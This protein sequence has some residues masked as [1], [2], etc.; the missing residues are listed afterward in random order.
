MHPHHSLLVSHARE[1]RRT[2]I[3]LYLPH[4]RERSDAPTPFSSC[5]TC[6]R[7]QTHP[8]HS[9]LVSHA[10]EV[11]RTHTILYLPHMRERSDAPTPFSTC[12]TCERGQTHPHH[13]LL[14]CLM[15]ERGQT[16]LT[17]LH[18]PHVRSTR[19]GKHHIADYHTFPPLLHVARV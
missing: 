16:H 10:R 8:H 19:D 12:L 15:C 18:L 4:M 5:L 3:I 13:S 11:R 7:G 2:H 17:I 6:E 14:A 1:V 9:L